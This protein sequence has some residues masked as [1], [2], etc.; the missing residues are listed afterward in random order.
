MRKFFY[1]RNYCSHSNRALTKQVLNKRNKVNNSMGLCFKHPLGFSLLALPSFFPY[2]TPPSL[3]PLSSCSHIELIFSFNAGLYLHFRLRPSI[4]LLP[5]AWFTSCLFFPSE[6]AAINRLLFWAL[7]P[8]LPHELE[9]VELINMASLGSFFALPSYPGSGPAEAL[10]YSLLSVSGRAEGSLHSLPWQE[11]QITR[12]EVEERLVIAALPPCLCEKLS[13]LQIINSGKDPP[14]GLGRG[15]VIGCMCIGWRK[16]EAG[17]LICA[18]VEELQLQ[19]ELQVLRSCCDRNWASG[20]QVQFQLTGK[21][22]H[23]TQP[24]LARISRLSAADSMAQS[25]DNVGMA[26]L[27][28]NLRRIYE[29]LS[30]SVMDN[31]EMAKVIKKMEDTVCYTSN[32][33]SNHDSRIDDTESNLRELMGTVEKI[34]EDLQRLVSLNQVSRVNGVCDE[35][36]Q[37]MEDESVAQPGGNP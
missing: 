26:D 3:P 8:S 2:P 4:P 31:R 22:I 11:L 6:A 35:A 19:K 12:S 24:Q 28:K 37:P 7:R 17:P 13:W 30:A 1:L 20:I 29:L 10:Y 14:A 32:Q 16:D 18:K 25:G 27:K 36:V 15:L 34:H 5:D 9:L 23:A 33:I 21:L